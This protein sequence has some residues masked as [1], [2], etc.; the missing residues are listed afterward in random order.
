[1]ETIY[2]ISTKF[3]KE[4]TPINDNVAD[5]LLNSSIRDAQTINLQQT[6]GTKLYKKVLD[7]V[8]NGTISD[9]SNAKYKVLLDEYI[10]PMVLQWAFVH[11]LPKIRYKMMNVGVVSQS[12]DNSNPVDFKELQYLIDEA[13]NNAE[14]Y[15]N[16]VTEYLWQN[17][18][19]YPEYLD[20]KH[21]DEKRPQIHQYTC[22]VVL[23]DIYPDEFP[24]NT[25][26]T[27]L[28]K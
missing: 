6:L 2:L 17:H 18:K 12:A 21:I 14:Y 28:T 24:Y 5:Y 23:S 19:D 26:P 8:K 16:L 15:S 4:N 11:C 9:E 7:L 20:N 25:F 27:Y 10:Q 3:L 22:G 1:M 13:R